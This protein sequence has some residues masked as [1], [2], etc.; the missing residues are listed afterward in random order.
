MGGHKTLELQ[1]YAINI[2]EGG[3]AA[4]FL[5]KLPSESKYFGKDILYLFQNSNHVNSILLMSEEQ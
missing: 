1:T 4:I 5:S 2:G 3:P